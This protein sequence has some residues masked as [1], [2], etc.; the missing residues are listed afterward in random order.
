MKC[1]TEYDIKYK[2]I[3]LNKRS[4]KKLNVRLKKK[5]LYGGKTGQGSF[6]VFPLIFTG[7]KT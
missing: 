6:A 5:R 2:I 7:S 4:S 3:R 1:E